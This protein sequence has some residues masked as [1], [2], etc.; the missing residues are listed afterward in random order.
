[1][2][3]PPYG[4]FLF[5]ELPKNKSQ[6]HTRRRTLKIV[7]LGLGAN[8]GNAIHQIYQALALLEPQV[9]VMSKSRCYETK[10]YGYTNQPNF[11][12]MAVKVWTTLKPQELRTF[13]KSIEDRL[14]RTRTR[15]NGPREIDIDILLYDRD[16]I[17]EC[18]LQI[19]H[20]GMRQRDF[21]LQPLL[22]VESGLC[23]PITGKRYA[24]YLEEIPFTQRY[25]VDRLILEPQRPVAYQIQRDDAVIIHNV[26]KEHE[27]EPYLRAARQLTYHEHPKEFGKRKVRQD[28]WSAR[29]ESGTLLDQLAETLTGAISDLVGPHMLDA[30]LRFTHKNVQRYDHG[31][32][33]ID[34]HKDHHHNYNLVALFGLGGEGLFTV[35]GRLMDSPPPKTQLRIKPGSLLLM[36]APGFCGEQYCP[37]HKVS[38]ITGTLDGYRYLLGLR[39]N[40]SDE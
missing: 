26:L 27:L 14:G 8:V 9:R 4:G 16:I 2:I 18:N 22:E 30:P 21:V 17:D 3:R 6:I 23:D 5:G 31:S 32:F 11:I 19:P 20:T 1:L 35:Y 25:V 10:P 38:E 24:D 33:G 34:T 15:E 37:W 40:D 7:Y 13:V 29:V 39:Q 28:V 12:N 36:K